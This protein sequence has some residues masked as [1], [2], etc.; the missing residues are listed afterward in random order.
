MNWILNHIWV[1]TYSLKKYSWWP[2]KI[3]NNFNIFT[4]D[5]NNIIKFYVIINSS[6]MIFLKKNIEYTINL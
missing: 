4:S 5:E 3:Q 6:Y 1:K 2:L